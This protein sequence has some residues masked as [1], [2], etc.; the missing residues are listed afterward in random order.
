MFSHFHG[1]HNDFVYMH[2]AKVVLGTPNFSLMQLSNQPFT[3]W[4]LLQCI[5]SVVLVKTIS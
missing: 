5:R 2:L 3:T 4:Q 1:H